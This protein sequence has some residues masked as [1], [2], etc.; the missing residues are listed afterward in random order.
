M[1]KSSYISEEFNVNWLKIESSACENFPKKY[2]KATNI[3]I[4][5]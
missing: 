4:Y 2:K 5:Q 3:F 1:F